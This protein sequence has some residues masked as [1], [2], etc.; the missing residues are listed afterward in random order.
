ME[1]VKTEDTLSRTFDP[2]ETG[3][4]LFGWNEIGNF[5]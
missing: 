4:G 1:E 3:L 2:E 5:I